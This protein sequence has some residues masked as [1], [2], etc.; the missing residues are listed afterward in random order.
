[1][2]CHFILSHLIAVCTWSTGNY[3]VLNSVI[4]LKAIKLLF[5]FL[6]ICFHSLSTVPL[7]LLLLSKLCPYCRCVVT[8]VVILFSQT[9]LSIKLFSNLILFKNKFF[10][11]AGLTRSK[12]IL[13]YFRNTDYRFLDVI[14]KVF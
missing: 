3:I 4:M 12:D 5:R 7:K 14:P 11:L 8:C 9:S 10:R 6:T 13:F 1:M 2:L